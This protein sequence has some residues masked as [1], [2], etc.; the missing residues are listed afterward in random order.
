[1]VC[2]TAFA[3]LT[4]STW[5]GGWSQSQNALKKADKETKNLVGQILRTPDLK[6]TES[7][8][9][10]LAK[11]GFGE[12]AT[13]LRD[14]AR[15]HG[16]T[17]I[18]LRKL[19]MVQPA[20]AA[21][22]F[23]A[24]LAAYYGIPETAATR[25][26]YNERKKL[27]PDEFELNLYDIHA[28]IR[29]GDHEY[30]YM[31][32]DM[33]KDAIADYRTKE[34]RRIRI[35]VTPAEVSAL[36]TFLEKDVDARGLYFT[37]DFLS[38][39][40]SQVNRAVNNTTSY[41]VPAGINRSPALTLGYFKFKKLVGDDRIVSIERVEGVHGARPGF[42]IEYSGA[43]IAWDI[44]D[45]ALGSFLFLDNAIIGSVI[46]KTESGFSFHRPNQNK[47]ADPKP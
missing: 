31:D 30:D 38:T 41:T 2:K 44:A 16:P 21:T 3:R 5:L 46:D 32:G 14:I 24:G 15:S 18:A 13:H 8:T 35:K 11:F 23:S 34:S 20:L 9:A 19:R 45:T 40:M 26:E 1:M 10:K 17:I 4:E 39:C 42:D 33:R 37:P 22:L 43:K 7:Q 12:D 47:Q 6:L 29:I 36:K 28:A 27:A 25:D